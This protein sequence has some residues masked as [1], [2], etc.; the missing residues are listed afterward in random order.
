[1]Q[2]F[3]NSFFYSSTTSSTLEVCF[4]SNLTTR[5]EIE[6]RRKHT[7]FVDGELEVLAVLQ[8]MVFLLSFVVC[9]RRPNLFDTSPSRAEQWRRGL[10][11]AMDDIASSLDCPPAVAPP[12]NSSSRSPARSVCFRRNNIITTATSITTQCNSI[13]AY[14]C[15]NLV[16]VICRRDPPLSWKLNRRRRRRR[17][18]VR[19]TN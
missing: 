16:Y 12:T 9:C 2:H 18:R 10:C 4:I 5:M 14:L 11:A 8:M 7:W 17:R 6:N 15:A 19:L 13:R 1:M 3:P